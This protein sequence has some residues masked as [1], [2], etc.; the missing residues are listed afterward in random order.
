MIGIILY[1]FIAIGF[2]L[3]FTTIMVMYSYY[4]IRNRIDIR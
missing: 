3:I 4:I 2:I 1:I